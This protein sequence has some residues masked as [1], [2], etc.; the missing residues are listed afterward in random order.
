MP[1][2]PKDE[3][4]ID[5]RFVRV[6]L[7]RRRRF[8][9][10]ASLLGLFAG[11]GIAYLTPPP[12]RG[13]SLIL[14]NAST[15]S[16]D[17]GDRSLP[18]DIATHAQIA[19]SDSVLERAIAISGSELSVRDLRGRTSVTTPTDSLVAVDVADPDAE[20]AVRLAGAIAEAHVGFLEQT[21]SPLSEEARASLESRLVDLQTQ[22]DQI[23]EELALARGREVSEQVPAD[24]RTRS[25]ELAGALSEKRAQLAIELSELRRELATVAEGPREDAQ[26]LEDATVATQ[27]SLFIRYA[28]AGLTGGLL[29]LF[30]GGLLAVRTARLDPGIWSIDALS[31]VLGAPVLAELRSRSYRSAGD[32]K[33]LLVSF[34]PPPADA[35]SV[36][37]ALRG[38]SLEAT[39]GRHASESTRTD[40]SASVGMA[41]I[42]LDKDHRGQSLAPVLAATIVS[43]GM[44]TALLGVGD[45]RSASSLWAGL[46]MYRRQASPRPGLQVVKGLGDAEP[47][48]LVVAMTI[49]EAEQPSLLDLPPARVHLLCLSPGAATVDDL[50]RLALAADASGREIVGALVADPD[51]W[52]RS[53]AGAMATELR[54][55]VTELP[56]VARHVDRAKRG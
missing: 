43:L 17:R 7:Q 9:L 55:S 10:L 45:P 11:L 41:L 23:D 8:V 40:R 5:L 42:A 49:V 25:A 50:S 37:R 29:G 26:V 2:L 13:T 46:A 24:Q 36:R 1:A 33:K 12:Y 3:Q 56:P 44:P 19:I 15:E 27:P 4:A 16:R 53:T 35:W 20:D 52:D 32:W 31:K 14:L 21:V 28:I 34:E 6:A 54:A 18:I 39:P 30:V 22:S 47:D 38:L 51:N 48:C